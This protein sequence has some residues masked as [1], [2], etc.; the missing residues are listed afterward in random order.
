MKQY[1]EN[2]LRPKAWNREFI[3]ENKYWH[4]K[5]S[6]CLSMSGP[7]SSYNSQEHSI[8][9]FKTFSIG[10]NAR[11]FSKA[12]LEVNNSIYYPQ[13]DI[14]ANKESRWYRALMRYR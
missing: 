11:Y 9:T 2:Y 13:L 4:T 5:A 3:F 12:Q 6:P 1:L 10:A 14:T 7:N 8:F